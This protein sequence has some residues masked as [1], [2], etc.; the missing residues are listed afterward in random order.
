MDGSK[1]RVIGGWDAHCSTSANDDPLVE[2][3]VQLA[4]GE[5]RKIAF[6]TVDAGPGTLEARVGPIT[7]GVDTSDFCRIETGLASRCK[8]VLTPAKSGEYLLTLKW[9]HF[10]VEGAP[11]NIVVHSAPAG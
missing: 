11:R 2:Q 1:L 7:D 10:D 6:N 3:A 5:E 9:G 8:L 4:V